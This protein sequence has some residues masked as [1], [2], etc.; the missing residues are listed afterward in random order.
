MLTASLVS[1]LM[2]IEDMFTQHLWH[3]TVLTI[4]SW[5]MVLWTLYAWIVRRERGVQLVYKL[6][7][8][9]ALLLAGYV[10]SNVVL[11]FVI[12]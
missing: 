4:L 10:L 12:Q 6:M 3:K 8:A 1:G 9:Y 7:L 5:L 11:Q 2:F